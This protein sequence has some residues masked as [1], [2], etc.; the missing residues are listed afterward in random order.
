MIAVAST[1]AKRDV[2]LAAGA[3]HAID[4]EGFLAATK[5]LTEGRGWT[6]SWT[7]SA[8]IASQTRCARWHRRGDCWSSGSPQATSRQ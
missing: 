2:A 5:E 8:V 3:D 4:V 1:A 6:L 7:P